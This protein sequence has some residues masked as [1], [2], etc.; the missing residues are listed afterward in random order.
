MTL[1][2]A[3]DSDGMA[4]PTPT[5]TKGFLAGS[6]ARFVRPRQSPQQRSSPK[7]IS[8]TH[9]SSKDTATGLGLGLSVGIAVTREVHSA[10]DIDH[11][12]MSPSASDREATVGIRGEDVAREREWIA[13]NESQRE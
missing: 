6:P 5:L 12:G 4:L 2:F 9:E 11:N 10:S 7:P 13:L 3:T 8:H 1:S